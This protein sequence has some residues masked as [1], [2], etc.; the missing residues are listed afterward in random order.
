MP[1]AVAAADRVG[2]GQRAC[3]E[4]GGAG[5]PGGGP[6]IRDEAFPSYAPEATRATLDALGLPA[7]IRKLLE[8]AL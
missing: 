2:L 5:V 8:A 7:P 6:S 4:P 1:V 3:Q